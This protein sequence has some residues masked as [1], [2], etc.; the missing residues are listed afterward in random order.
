MKIDEDFFNDYTETF[1]RLYAQ[2]PKQLIHGSPTGD[3]AIYENGEIICFKGFE[4][5]SVSQ[6]RIYDVI[7]CAGEINA[8]PSFDVYL[9][10]LKEIIK[11][12]DSLNPLT[13]E[14]KQSF[15][16]VMC[17]IGMN[18]IAWCDETWDVSKRNREALVFLS[19]SKQLFADL[20]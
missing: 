7:Y 12:Y 2:L 14:E 8:Q 11:G 17:S 6:L 18:M 15:Y 4:F 19:K 13:S 10:T 1:G 20:I 9:K 3:S 16:Y 5:Y